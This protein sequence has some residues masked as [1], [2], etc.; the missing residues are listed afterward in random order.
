MATRSEK[1]TTRARA[2]ILRQYLTG[3]FVESVQQEEV[4]GIMDLCLSCKAC[5]TECP[6]GVDVAKMKAEFMQAYHD[7]H[8]IPFRTKLIAGFGT[9]MQLAS[10]VAPLYNTLVQLKP[11][12]Q[13]INRIAGFHPERTLP[14]VSAQSLRSWFGERQKGRGKR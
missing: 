8:G 14:E 11:V 12:R 4:K 6:S 3:G 7:S 13:L 10:R 9:Q 2:N 1:D 5:K